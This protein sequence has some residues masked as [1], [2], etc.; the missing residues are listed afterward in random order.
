[1]MSNHIKF[2]HNNEQYLVHFRASII[3]ARFI[4]LDIHMMI[5]NEYQYT[6]IRWFI[7]SANQFNT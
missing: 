7:R 4:N 1:M 5:Q 6:I 3:L 2:I